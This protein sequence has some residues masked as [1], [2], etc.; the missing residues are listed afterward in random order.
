MNKLFYWLSVFIF[1]GLINPILSRSDIPKIKN[2]EHSKD[3]NIKIDNKEISYKRFTNLNYSGRKIFKNNENEFNLPLN[4]KKFFNNFLVSFE[5]DSKIKN[6][7]VQELEILADY[8]EIA[9]SIISAKGNVIIR[10]KKAV[11]NTDRFSYDREK[12]LLIIEGDIKFKSQNQFLLASKIQYDFKNKKGFILD[13]Y[14]S[15]NFDYLSEFLNNEKNDIAIDD[16]FDEDF[17]IKKVKLDSSSNLEFGNIIRERKQETSFKN[18]SDNSINAN[19]NP[20]RRTRFISERINIF[21]NLWNAE[22]LYL[23]NDPFNDAQLIVKNLDFKII[24]EEEKTKIRTKWSNLIF[25]NN[26]TIPIGPRR[27]NVDREKTFK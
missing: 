20:V 19:I 3:G 8:E 15:V 18:F 16:N 17:K 7:N 14:G 21:D 23:T 22:T 25:E 2:S 26:V 24:V 5:N 27:I 6:S 12:S 11:L 1:F 9:G 4:F 13:A 10:N